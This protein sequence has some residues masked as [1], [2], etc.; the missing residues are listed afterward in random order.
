MLFL[1]ASR[2]S[3]SNACRRVAQDL[4]LLVVA[5]TPGSAQV[6]QGTVLE[7]SSRTP[8]TAAE[9]RL[10]ARGRS[11]G[12]STLA[13]DQGRFVLRAP[14]AGRYEIEARRIGYQVKTLPSIDLGQRMELG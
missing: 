10:I 1:G 11:V 14:R 4:A 9:V 3:R 5:A 8:V 6:I 13:D 2:R 12:A 7:D